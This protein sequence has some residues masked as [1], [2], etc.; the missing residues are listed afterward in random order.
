MLKG[1]GI[2]W[3]NGDY[4]EVQTNDNVY[5]APYCPQF[6]YSNALIKGRYLLYKDV[7]R[8][9]NEGL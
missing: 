7:N 9:Y 6:L 1:S 2:Y 3:F 4:H 8:D 5:M